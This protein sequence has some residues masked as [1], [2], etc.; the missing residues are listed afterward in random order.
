[1]PISVDA[2]PIHFITNKM[3]QGK[4]LFRGSNARAQLQKLFGIVAHNGQFDVDMLN[5]KGLYPPRV[6]SF[7]R[8]T[9]LGFGDGFRMHEE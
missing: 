7:A 5:R 3:V 8:I 9:E 6:I 1:M 2:M 4:S